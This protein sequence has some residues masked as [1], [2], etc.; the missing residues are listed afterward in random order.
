[1]SCDIITSGFKGART[2]GGARAGTVAKGCNSA[3]R[4]LFQGSM[5]TPT[6]AQHATAAILLQLQ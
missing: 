6:A 4:E 1:M 5:D 2:C 3:S